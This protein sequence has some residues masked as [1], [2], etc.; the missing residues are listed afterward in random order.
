M[1]EKN[2]KPY[3]SLDYEES[4]IDLQRLGR[5]AKMLG[6]R[7]K[8]EITKQEIPRDHPQFHYL[9]SAPGS[10]WTHTGIDEGL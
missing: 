5:F 2:V 6:A 3:L 10:K 4:D 1:K 7:T 8:L 9:R